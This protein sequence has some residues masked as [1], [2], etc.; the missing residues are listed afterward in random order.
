[1]KW[2][3]NKMAEDSIWTFF[4]LLIDDETEKKIL[5]FLILDK[6]PEEIIEK[7]LKAKE[8]EASK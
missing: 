8:I 6:S 7:L 1:M 3:T 2:R 4:N 5:K